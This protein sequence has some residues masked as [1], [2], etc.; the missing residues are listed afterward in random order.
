MQKIEL[1]IKRMKTF[2]DDSQ[3]E[4]ERN[5]FLK[6][7][8]VICDRF[9]KGY[10][11]E[12]DFQQRN[13]FDAPRRTAE[14]FNYFFGYH[15]QAKKWSEILKCL[16]LDRIESV[17]DI[18][19]GWSPKIEW[20]L[21]DLNFEGKVYLLDL[22]SEALR[23]LE[24]LLKIYQVKYSWEFL[25]EDFFSVDM[26]P[27]DLLVA[28]H[29]FDDLV[30]E[31]YCRRSGILLESLYESEALIRKATE[32]AILGKHFCKDEFCAKVVARIDNLV[33]CERYVACMHYQGLTER[34][35]ELADWTSFIFELMENVY[36]RLCVLGYCPII[37]EKDSRLLFILQK[38]IKDKGP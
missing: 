35:L 31:Q 9:E 24:R 3:S 16:P 30:L 23:R 4:W 21:S 1:L 27:V 6:D 34:A 14:F 32:N 13:Q 29:A 15:E 22:S 26:P 5:N 38:G 33:K 11:L 25:L 7:L 10:Y 17:L 12:T 37:K 36:S 8:E 2:S 19:P 28:N 20:A 18:C